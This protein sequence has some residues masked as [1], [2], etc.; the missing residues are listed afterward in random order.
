MSRPVFG[1]AFGRGAPCRSLAS[2]PGGLAAGFGLV[3]SMV[4]LAILSFGLLAL[5]YMQTW[6]QRHAQAAGART[7]ATLIAGELMERVR[8]AGVPIDS[9]D[10]LGLVSAPG[11]ES[12]CLPESAS[13]ANA[14]DCFHTHIRERVPAGAG[15]IAIA[16]RT[17]LITVAWLDRHDRFDDESE[18]VDAATCEA[19]GRLWHEDPRLHWHPSTPTSQRPSCLAAQR[20]SLMP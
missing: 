17:L 6:G 5:A 15:G 20:W 7:Q 4:T 16:G 13:L 11:A 10:A 14:R 9:P 12:A 2:R 19:S 18:P 3:E 1:A 8:A